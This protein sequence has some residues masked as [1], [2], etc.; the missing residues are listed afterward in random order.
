M[1]F[2]NDLQT[3]QN[4]VLRLC[5]RYKLADRVPIEQLHREAKLQS[6]DQRSEFHLLKLL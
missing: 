1:Y 6:I 4:N 2:R 3:F 5:L